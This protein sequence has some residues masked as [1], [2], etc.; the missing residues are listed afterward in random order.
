MLRLIQVFNAAEVLQGLLQGTLRVRH[1]LAVR[2]VRVLLQVFNA[3]EVLQG[4]PGVPDLG[5]PELDQRLLQGILRVQGVL[6]H[7][8]LQ[9]ARRHGLAHSSALGPADARDPRS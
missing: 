4:V 3:A 5:I 2:G 1:G 8:L 7:G 6:L 9:G